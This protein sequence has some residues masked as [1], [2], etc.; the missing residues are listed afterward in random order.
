MQPN[1]ILSAPLIDLIFEGQNKEYGAYELRKTYSNRINKALLITIALA[2]MIC[3]SAFMANSSKKNRGPHVDKGSVVITEIH[4]KKIEEPIPEKKPEI[5][6]VKTEIFTA[7]EIKEDKEVETPPPTQ[8]ELTNVKIGTEIID[9]GE[10][11]TSIP[12]PPNQLISTCQKEK[13]K[14]L[15]H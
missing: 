6:P 9:S 1:N 4:E 3:C 5:K 14:F 13:K 12:V 10:I 15:L 11:Y 8:E 2:G 7:P